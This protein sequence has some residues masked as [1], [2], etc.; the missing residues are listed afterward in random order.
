MMMMTVVVK[1]IFIT[2]LQNLQIITN[3]TE[4]GCRHRY[5]I[6]LQSVTSAVIRA[7]DPAAHLDVLTV[8]PS[9]NRLTAPCPSAVDGH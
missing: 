2:E 8:R 5:V 1:V 6:P 9:S 7:V 3:I 4:S